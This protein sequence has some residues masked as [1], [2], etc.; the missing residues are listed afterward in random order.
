MDCSRRAWRTGYD[1]YS[2]LDR[3][4]RFGAASRRG[5]TMEL[6]FPTRR[7][8]RCYLDSRSAIR[9]WGTVVGLRYVER[10]R[11]IADLDRIE[12]LHRIRALDFH[13]LTRPRDGQQAIRLTG[14]MR[15]IVTIDE[16]RM[17]TIVE[18]VDYHS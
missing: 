16:P 4:R 15:L 2:R 1:G 6:R 5:L 13:P 18:V 9:E 10:L 11:Q 8:Q 3:S 7:L 17:V 12:D 14:Q